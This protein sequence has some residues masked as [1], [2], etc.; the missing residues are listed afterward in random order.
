M[1]R[2]YENPLEV[3][4]PFKAMQSLSSTS[5]NEPGKEDRVLIGY[6]DDGTAI[7]AR[8]PFGKI[9]EE[10]IG[11]MTSPFD[12]VHRKLSTFARPISEVDHN[13]RGFGRKLYNP[14][15][16]TTQEYVKNIGRIAAAFVGQ[17]LPTDSAKAALA[18]M[19]GDKTGKTMN[20][21]KVF[22]P[23]A[24]LTFSK[25]APGGPAAGE[26][27]RA[28]DQHDFAVQQ[29]MPDIRAMIKNGE[30]KE[31]RA[32]MKELGIPHGLQDYYVKSTKHPETYVKGRAAKDFQKY[33]TPEQV[34]RFNQARQR[35]QTFKQ[36]N[37]PA[38]RQFEIDA[39]PAP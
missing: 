17:Q 8:N 29:A 11:W 5:E 39:P 36:N 35:T 19:R 31:A 20:Q 22:G 38:P 18:L 33:G 32:L 4:Q 2:V 26:L 12:M 13:D 37:P 30:E 27:F 23:L 25:G 15:A 34:E 21:Y 10:F 14:Y 6:E 7:Y 1:H 28:R 9:G 3:L 16:D 24:G